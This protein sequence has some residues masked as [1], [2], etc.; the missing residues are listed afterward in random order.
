M[1]AISRDL[2]R[3]QIV[4]IEG[5]ADAANT[6]PKILVDKISTEFRLTVSA[7][8]VPA[9]LPTQPDTV[10]KTTR[11]KKASPVKTA[12]QA[13]ARQIAE[14]TPAYQVAAPAQK[15]VVSAPEPEM[16]PPPPAFPDGW[17][18]MVYDFDHP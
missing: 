13:P 7:D 16:P 2:R 6:P 1:A 12:P 8:E 11:A 14:P 10:K 3:R 9:R 15:P 5:K 17:K 4:I 18:E